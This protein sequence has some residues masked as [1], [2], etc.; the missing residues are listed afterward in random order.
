MTSTIPNET[1]TPDE[2]ASSANTDAAA[3]RAELGQ[4]NAELAVI[5]EIG[6]A[7]AKQLDFQGIVDAVGD[8][9]SEIL[10][11]LDLYIAIR[12]DSDTITFPYWTEAGVRDYDV[13]PLK[14]GEG[15][16][17]QVIATGRSIRTGSVEAA[18]TLGAVLYGAEHQSYLGVPIGRG[19]RVVGVLSISKPE[20]DAF[21][22]GDEQLVATIASSMGVALE[23]ARLFAETQRLLDETAQR[24][25]ELSIINEDRRRAG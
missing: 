18:A 19:D 6:V 15:V 25:A 9:V 21:S 12:V 20:P 16:T 14:F 8:K 23:N 4:R 10:E 13:P 11:S 2:G 24:A 1:T 5:N 22:E 3:L 7:L 17:S